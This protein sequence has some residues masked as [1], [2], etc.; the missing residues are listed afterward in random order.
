MKLTNIYFK[1]THL[2]EWV[3]KLT[4]CHKTQVGEKGETLAND[5]AWRVIEDQRI[6]G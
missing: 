2:F 1:T 4:K 5:Q 3:V 6:N